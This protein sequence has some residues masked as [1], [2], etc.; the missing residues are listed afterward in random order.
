VPGGIGVIS[1]DE[2]DSADGVAC[3]LGAGVGVV[4]GVAGTGITTG[5]CVVIRTTPVGDPER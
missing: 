4:F 1:S 5:I 2:N 3:W